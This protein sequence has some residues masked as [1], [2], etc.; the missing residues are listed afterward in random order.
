MEG[1]KVTQEV[2][3]QAEAVKDPFISSST[4]Q[5]SQVRVH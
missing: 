2:E 4:G 5:G 3:T 1:A